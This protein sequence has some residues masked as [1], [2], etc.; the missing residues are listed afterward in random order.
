MKHALSILIPRARSIISQKR[1][2]FSMIE[3]LLAGSLLALVV[4]TLS[5]ILIFGQESSRIAGDSQ[6]ATALAEEGLEAVRSMSE[7]SFSSLTAGPHGLAVSG[8]KWQFLGT[9]DYPEIFTRSLII[10]DLDANTKVVTSTVSW[11]ASSQRNGSISLVGRFTNWRRVGSSMDSWASTTN[12]GFDFN[13]AGWTFV[14]NWVHKGNGVRSG[15]RKSLGGN[16]GGYINM[17]V[18]AKK[19]KDEAVY[20]YQPFTTTV[21]S[22]AS[23]TLNLDWKSITFGTTATTYR[24]YVFIDASSTNPILGTQVWDSGEITGTTAWASAPT[25]DIAGKIP[26]AGTY[27]V[28]IGAYIMNPNKNATFVTGLDNVTVKWPN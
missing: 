16:S 28:K 23:S 2:A 11:S 8:G 13:S 10:S 27:Y 18:A 26:T 25:I 12:P 19:N 22:P 3:A 14:N 9:Q 6:R 5:G 7:A 17:S 21:D 4:F 24:I 1:L 20:W 15:A